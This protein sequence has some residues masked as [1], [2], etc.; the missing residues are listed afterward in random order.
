MVNHELEIE[1]GDPSAGVAL[2]GGRLLDVATAPPEPEITALDRVEKHRPIDLV[3][4]HER[5][6]GVALELGEAEIGPERRDDRADEVRE[7]VL[8]V[9]QLDVGEVARVSGDVGDQETGGLRD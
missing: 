4:R 3:G 6:R 7:D 5:E 8:C 2:A 1:I 9:A